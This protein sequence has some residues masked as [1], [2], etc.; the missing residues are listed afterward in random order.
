[1]KQNILVVVDMQND[2]ITG[3]L[4]SDMAMNIMPNVKKIID[5][6][7]EENNTVIFTRD[8]HDASKYLD[9]NEGKQLPVVH[10]VK[11]TEGWQIPNELTE[12]VKNALF[13]NKET[14][15]YIDWKN[16][17]STVNNDGSDLNITIIGLCTDICVVSNAI[18][19][20]AVF[21]EANVNVIANCC[22]G[23]TEASHNAALMTM[24]SCQ[25]NIIE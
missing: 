10:C 24:K 13:I 7:V 5:E 20:K 14:F 4:G 18:I 17:I 2:F 9:T 21:P 3:A 11:D 6:A 22:A 19:L 16:I 8:T 1:M 23:V 12:N 15:G 25:V